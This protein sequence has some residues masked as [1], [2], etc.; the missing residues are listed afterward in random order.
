MEATATESPSH[1]AH[2][3]PADGH[4]IKIAL[5]LGVLTAAETATYFFDLFD[6]TTLLLLFLMP[7]MVIKF[8]TV[9]WFFMH[10]GS[11]SRV[12]TRFF[13]GGIVLATFVYM[14]FL[15]TFDEFF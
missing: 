13:L 11:D 7:V 14:I 8:G 6:N 9:A 15:L 10:L 2:A 3:H 12:F 5:F 1:D 4:Y